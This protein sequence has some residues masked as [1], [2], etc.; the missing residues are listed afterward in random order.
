METHHHYDY[1][2]LKNAAYEGD[3]E[4]M[5]LIK[6]SI[7]RN[8]LR[9]F[10]CFDFKIIKDKPDVMKWII[11]NNLY[12]DYYMDSSEAISCSLMLCLAK[13]NTSVLIW[14]YTTIKKEID[15]E[16]F[17]FCRNLESMKFLYNE[18]KD[19]IKDENIED[20][21]EDLFYDNDKKNNSL[22]C[23]QLMYSLAP[24]EITPKMV[25]L[26]FRYC[27]ID[28]IK[29]IETIAPFDINKIEYINTYQHRSDKLTSE[30][31]SECYKDVA[32][33]LI[34]NNIYIKNKIKEDILIVYK[35]AITNHNFDTFEYIY[36]IYGW[37]DEINENI[38]I[39]DNI[40]HFG[41]FDFIKNHIISNDK[42][43]KI[44]CFEYSTI[45]YRYDILFYIYDNYK[46]LIT[47]EVLT[48]ILTIFN[49]IYKI[50]HWCKRNKINRTMYRLLIRLG[51]RNNYME[52]D[53]EDFKSVYKIFGQTIEK[54]LFHYYF[55]PQ[56]LAFN[57]SMN[58]FYKLASF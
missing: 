41:S 48:K 4:K 26:M 17:Q 52:M 43:D 31:F 9:P 5:E 49:I 21:F 53:L 12:E 14:Y 27:S 7:E 22:E 47:K 44:K 46:H 10:Y 13:Y 3:I 20:L 15:I 19:E 58:N 34:N 35:I 51:A 29:W 24:F 42:C 56:G 6:Q 38:K 11:L 16:A 54:H 39:L 40:I 30:L 28:I 23:L 32:E 36:S 45:Y 8:K 37:I 57:K 25:I 50:P 33:Y 18:Y 2:A 1:Y 55:K